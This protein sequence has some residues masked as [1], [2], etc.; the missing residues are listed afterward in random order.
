MKHIKVKALLFSI[1]LGL[2]LPVSAMA[3]ISSTKS[4]KEYIT[5]ANNDVNQQS[6]R[7]DEK[8]GEWYMITESTG[9]HRKGDGAFMQTT[10]VTL[11]VRQG[12]A[13]GETKS[14]S[15]PITQED[16]DAGAGD[17]THTKYRIA[18]SDDQ[19]HALLGDKAYNALIDRANGT[20]HAYVEVNGQLRVSTDGTGKL[21]SSYPVYHADGHV[22]YTS[23]YSL[24][25]TQVSYTTDGKTTKM[26]LK[27]AAETMQKY[28][29]NKN[30][31]QAAKEAAEAARDQ[32]R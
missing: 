18:A 32:A 6:L 28:T 19:I 25:N 22:T 2:M 26:T 4:S 5:I 17:Y 21:W 10:S 16:L 24:M 14:V 12:N 31:A 3:E 30:A 29:D 8:T 13:L 9:D 27:E 15:L 20:G 1:A 23:M 7:R 11:T